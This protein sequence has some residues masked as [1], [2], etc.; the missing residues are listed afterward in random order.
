MASNYPKFRQDPKPNLTLNLSGTGTSG[1]FRTRTTEAKRARQDSNE[2]NVQVCSKCDKEIGEG[3]N[4]SGCKQLFCFNC[5]GISKGLH[6]CLLKGEL[7]DFR[8]D[9]KCCKSLFPSLDNISKVLQDIR[10]QHDSRLYAVESRLD[11]IEET[12]K[13]SIKES[14]TEL[15][16][17]IIDGIKDDINNLVDSR[18]KELEDR[19]RRELNLTIFSLPEYNYPTGAENKAKDELD[20]KYI[21]T[22]LGLQEIK[23]VTCFRLGKKQANKTRPLKVILAEKAQRKFMLENA[24]FI[25]TKLP[26]EWKNVIVSKDL[27]PVQREER[28]KFISNKKDSIQTKKNPGQ[29]ADHQNALV[30]ND[31]NTRRFSFRTPRVATS[32]P[33]K[34]NNHEKNTHLQST[35][36]D[37]SNNTSPKAAME[38]ESIHIS[39]ISGNLSNINVFE[40]TAQ[41]SSFMSKNSIY[42]ETTLQEDDTTIIGGT[43]ALLHDEPVSPTMD[44]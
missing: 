2:D 19:R 6:N 38:T 24:K 1:L 8:W 41:N 42:N 9:C 11:T 13:Y 18:N 44:R 31:T 7:D 26:P 25:P 4:C 34:T 12:T 32:R 28:K 29:N 3:I 17:E 14:V 10:T 30:V 35:V 5:A 27:T 33:E 39:P 16:T 20:V 15:K 22:K 36:L 23:I 21:S 37:T 43:P 40:D